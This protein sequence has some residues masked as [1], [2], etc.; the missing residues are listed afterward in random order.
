MGYRKP[1][2]DEQ[3]IEL[4]NQGIPC[5]DIAARIG[6][7]RQTVYAALKR[8]GLK[9]QL[10]SDKLSKNRQKAHDNRAKTAQ[11]GA[12]TGQNNPKKR[13]KHVNPFS[14]LVRGEYEY[15]DIRVL[16]TKMAQARRIVDLLEEQGGDVVFDDVAI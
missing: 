9:G 4:R 13:K 8:L 11:N 7:P 16:P 6:V 12:K 1:K 14:V 5:V 2:Y 3:I 15:I 10:R